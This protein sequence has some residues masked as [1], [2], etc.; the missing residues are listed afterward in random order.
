MADRKIILSED[1]FRDPPPAGPAPSGLGGQ[2]PPITQSSP[3]QVPVTPGGGQQAAAG[4]IATTGSVSPLVDPRTSFLIAAA[5]G[6]LLGWG[7]TQILGVGQATFFANKAASDRS[8]AIWVGVIGVLYGATLLSF[9]RAVAGAWDAVAKRVATA[10]IPLL[11]VGYVAGY[12]ANAL[13]LQI[14][15]SASATLTSDN[16]IRLYLARAAGWAVFGLGI[17]VTIG[18]VD[19][20]KSRAI[21]G[22]IGGALGG[23]AGGIVFQFAAANLHTSD[24]VSRLL[25][26]AGVG[27]LIAVATRVVETARREAWVRVLSGGMAGKEFILYHA[28]TRIGAS[29]DC[30]IFLLKDPGVAKLHA[31]V[32]DRSGRRTLT[33]ASGA[34]VYVNGTSIASHALRSGDQVQIGNTVLGYSERAIAPAPAGAFPGAR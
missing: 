21:N 26:L 10:A 11:I 27:F 17:G 1:D 12:A 15:Q 33:A 6:V 4:R 30:E 34:P 3:L 18:L 2:L 7:V 22:A 31:Q 32:D 24:S 28:I 29:S 8:A 25:G 16:D 9:D 5:V 19:R 23:A 13:Y 20:S 14:L